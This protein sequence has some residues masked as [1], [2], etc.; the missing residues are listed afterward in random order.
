MISSKTKSEIN[1]LLGRPSPRANIWEVDRHNKD[2]PCDKILPT[3]ITEY[4]AYGLMRDFFLEHKEYT[5]LVIATDDIIVLPKHVK[6]LQ[7]D[8]EKYDFPV[9]SGMMNVNQN[10]RQD[11]NLASPIFAKERKQRSLIW[12]QRDSL[13]KED[14]FQV[15]FSGFPLMAIRRDLVERWTFDAD[16]VLVGQQGWKGASLDLVFCWRC[17]EAGIPVFVD[18]R[19]D[20]KH[21]RSEGTMNTHRQNRLIFWPKGGDRIKLECVK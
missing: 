9:L 11:V 5:H 6:Q 20:M 1:L 18:K 2:L 7:R 14:I 10:D 4:I 8:L 12:L 3:Y 16:K 15:E 21:L 19:I 17:K 13:P